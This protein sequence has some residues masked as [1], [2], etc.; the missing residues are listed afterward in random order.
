[1]KGG[2]SNGDDEEE[3]EEQSGVG[4][5]TYR[6]SVSFSIHV[7]HIGNLI[8]YYND[9]PRLL[10]QMLRSTIASNLTAYNGLEESSV[11]DVLDI[12]VEQDSCLKGGANL[13]SLWFDGNGM[14][15]TFASRSA[16]RTTTTKQSASS[17]SFIVI[18]IVI[19]KQ[20]GV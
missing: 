20:G 10:E 8:Q 14:D 5:P 19:R 11:E 4:A 18:V 2:G 15:K 17:P 7:A 6:P 16:S 3:D 1:M 12:F 13:H 9:C